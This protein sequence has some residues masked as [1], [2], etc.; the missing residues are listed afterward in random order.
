METFLDD[1]KENNFPPCKNTHNEKRDENNT[2]SSKNG[3]KNN[4]RQDENL[5]LSQ[6]DRMCEAYHQREDF[7]RLLPDLLSPH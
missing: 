2:T 4:L 6:K 5:S 3:S 1:L 7:W